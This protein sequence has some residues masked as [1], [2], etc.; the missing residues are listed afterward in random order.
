MTKRKES[1]KYDLLFSAD[2]FYHKELL[3]KV[4]GRFTSIS[5]DDD[6]LFVSFGNDSDRKACLKNVR[7]YARFVAP[8]EYEDCEP[9]QGVIE[10]IKAYFKGV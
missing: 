6:K 9:K 8:V 10:R 7:G 1:E 3:E 2:E 5:R 4:W